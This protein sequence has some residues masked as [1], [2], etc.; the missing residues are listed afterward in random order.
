MHS[1]VFG[2]WWAYIER[3]YWSEPLDGTRITWEASVWRTRLN[4]YVSTFWKWSVELRPA[5]PPCD[6]VVSVRVGPLHF[7]HYRLV[8]GPYRWRDKRRKPM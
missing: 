5:H 1:E 6:R 7:C 8:D 3:W 4:C 2:W